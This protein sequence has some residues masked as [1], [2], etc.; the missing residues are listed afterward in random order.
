MSP[1]ARDSARLP[2]TPPPRRDRLAARKLAERHAA[3]ARVMARLVRPPSAEQR[4]FDP[5][6]RGRRGAGIQLLVAALAILVS[7]GVHSGVYG[8]G[9]W[10]GGAH[11]RTRRRDLVAIE[12]R[13]REPEPEKT[14]EEPPPPPE[15]KQV[16]ERPPERRKTEPP[17]EKPRPEEPGKPPPR[18]TGLSLDSTAQGGGGPSFAVG[19][20]RQGRTAERAVDP[21][22]VGRKADPPPSPNQT[23]SRVP[24]TGASYVLPRRRRRIEPSYPQKLVS[25]G[26][27]AA[28]TVMVSLDR[29]GKVVSVKIIK[30]SGYPEFDDS[31]RKTAFAESFEPATRDG[32]PIPYTLSYTYHFN[33]TR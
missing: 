5:L 6:A 14:K 29:T 17:P 31:A 24:G 33:L 22:V 12:V 13:E 23:A 10:F 15:E 32:T 3:R 2:A 30:S 19:N 27:E 28:V 11:D 7:A 16:I 25:Q 20:T 8:F 26:I 21:A 4:A 9:F 1:P 18:V